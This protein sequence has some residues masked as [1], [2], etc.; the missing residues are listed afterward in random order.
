[1]VNI[2]GQDLVAYQVQVWFGDTLIQGQNL[3]H[4]L[5]L[6]RVLVPPKN[7]PRE[8]DTVTVRV[9]SNGSDV[10]YPNGPLQFTYQVPQ[11]LPTIDDYDT[12]I[13]DSPHAVPAGEPFTITFSGDHFISGQRFPTSCLVMIGERTEFATYFAGT[14]SDREVACRFGGVVL[15]G[16]YQFIVGFSD[17]AAAEIDAPGFVAPLFG[18]APIITQAQAYASQQAVACDMTQILEE[19]LCSLYGVPDVHAQPG[20]VVFQVYYTAVDLTALVFDPDSTATQ[21]DILLASASYEYIDPLGQPQESYQVLL[22][23]GSA[24]KDPSNQEEIAWL[25]DCSHSTPQVCSCQPAVY[26]LTSN[27]VTASDAVYTRRLA[28]LQDTTP[29]LFHDCV[30]SQTH[31]PTVQVPVGSDLAWKFYAVDRSGNLTAWP[32]QPTTTIGADSYSCAGDPCGCCLMQSQNPAQP[33]PEGCRGLEGMTSPAY[34]DG[35][36]KALF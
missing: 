15:P 30:T 5:Q 19:N 34:P 16:D 18:Y 35:L 32:V 31:R 36:C 21:N 27:D 23:D 6:L 2:Q 12:G 9:L 29:A 8:P 10:P 13:P 1:V 24:N 4:N 28:F 26:R 14:P 11:P 17:G 3:G 33:P 22:D 7:D 20:G 25:E